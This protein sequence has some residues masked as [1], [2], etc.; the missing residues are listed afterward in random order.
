MSTFFE[1]PLPQSSIAVADPELPAETGTPENDRNVK[2]AALIILGAI[3]LILLLVFLWYLFFR[4]PLQLP[5]MGDNRIPSF[6]ANFYGPNT[7]MGVAADPSADRVYVT[8][9]AG[10][11]DTGVYDRAG[12]QIGALTPPDTNTAHVP[13]Y[14][15]VNPT[16]G[17]VYVTDRITR[18]IYIYDNTGTYQ[19]T[20]EPAG[21]LK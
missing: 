14:V 21:D 1:D 17:D 19:R 16:N 8:S 20:Y 12:Q 2:K 6:S 18:Q 10:T 13:V 9:S 3:A 15:A 5:G 4:K 7:P 11:A